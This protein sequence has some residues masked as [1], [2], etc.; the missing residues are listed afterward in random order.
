M[1]PWAMILLSTI[2]FEPHWP[3]RLGL[4]PSGPPP[5]H[6]GAKPKAAAGA[7][8]CAAAHGRHPLGRR[9]LG[10]AGSW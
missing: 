5:G 1:F 9:R 2:F 7:A 6:A 4:I 8:G 10:R 3:R